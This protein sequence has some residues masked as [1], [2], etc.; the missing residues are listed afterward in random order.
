MTLKRLDSI[1]KLDQKSKSQKTAQTMAA[2]AHAREWRFPPERFVSHSRHFRVRF[3][4][5]CD[6]CARSRVGSL[7]TSFGGFR[8]FRCLESQIQHKPWQLERTQVSGASLQKWFVCNPSPFRVHNVISCDFRARSHVGFL[9]TS[10]SGVS[11]FRCL[12]SQK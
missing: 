6:V 9:P 10:S 5:S 4:I 3:V 12:E 11:V 1:M 2:R 8:A 7:A